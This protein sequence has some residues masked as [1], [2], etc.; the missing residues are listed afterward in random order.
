MHWLTRLKNNSWKI[1][2]RYSSKKKK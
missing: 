1:C 2:W